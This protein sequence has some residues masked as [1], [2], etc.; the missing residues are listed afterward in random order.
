MAGSSLWAR[1]VVVGRFPSKARWGSSIPSPVVPGDV[2]LSAEL[3]EPLVV[4][5]DVALS[6]ELEEPLV[7][8]GDVALSAELE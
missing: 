5:G 1:I 8:P 7:V 6:A 2:A 4:P 3:E